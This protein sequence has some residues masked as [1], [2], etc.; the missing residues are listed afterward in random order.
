M[1][2]VISVGLRSFHKVESQNGSYIE[3]SLRHRFNLWSAEYTFLNTSSLYYQVHHKNNKKILMLT[4]LF[5]Y[6]VN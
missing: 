2:G 1:K 6:L 5:K 4:L 3:I